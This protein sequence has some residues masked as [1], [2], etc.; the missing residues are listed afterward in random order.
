[1]REIALIEAKHGF[2]LFNPSQDIAN[3][4]D[5][6][7]I[8]EKMRKIQDS[9]SGFFC[10]QCFEKSGE[11]NPVRFRNNTKDRV[12]FFHTNGKAKC[13]WTGESPDHM[14][15]KFAIAAD[16]E[17][18]GCGAEIK[19]DCITL[20]NE[21]KRRKPDVLAIYPNGALEAHEIQ[22]SPISIEVWK[23][24]TDDQKSLGCGSVRWYFG[25]E[26]SERLIL[27]ASRSSTECY[28]LKIDELSVTWKLIPRSKERAKKPSDFIQY[29]PDDPICRYSRKQEEIETES[30]GVWGSK[31]YER[32]DE[33]ESAKR[34]VKP[35]EPIQPL[36]PTPYKSD[37]PLYRHIRKSDWVGEFYDHPW[38]M[39]GVMLDLIWIDSPNGE[40][41]ERKRK[42]ERYPVK[43]L[44]PA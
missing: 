17:S 39:E 27:E 4:G 6:N 29:K 33:T 28:R 41:L 15:A 42:P 36:E 40:H 32:V 26:I 19:I 31:R 23:K 21:E 24:R 10:P 8:V 2:L 38:G 43:D 25:S 7:V 44:Y 35:P 22:L 1:M 18:K 14:R 34:Q 9:P 13:A 16:L 11:K 30:Q 20:K 3:G 12:C 5:R 37:K